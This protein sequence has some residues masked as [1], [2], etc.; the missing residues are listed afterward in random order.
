MYRFTSLFSLAA[1]FA[2]C[3]IEDISDDVDCADGKCDGGKDLCYAEHRYSNGTCDAECPQT[4]VDCLML[5]DDQAQA[6]AW[7]GELEKTIAMQ[8]VRQPRSFVATNDPRFVRMRELLDRGWQSYKKTMPVKM[9]PKTPELV[10]IDDDTA[11]AFVALDRASNKAAW[12]VM[13]QTGAIKDQSDDALLGVVM[14]ELTHATKLHVLPT[15]PDR[16]R[17]H[18]QVTP[19]K[20]EPFGFQ[21]KDQANARQAITAWRELGDAAGPNAHAELNGMPLGGGVLSTMLNAALGTANPANCQATSAKATAVNQFVAAHT[22]P[23]TSL[24]VVSTAADRTQLDQLTRALLSDL[25]DI[26]LKDSTLDIFQLMAQTFGVSAEEVAAEFPVEEQTRLKGKHIIDQITLMAGERHQLMRE[27]AS[28]V[29][30]N[31]GRDI[32]TLRYFSFEE[33]ADDATVPVLRDMGLAVDGVGQFFMNLMDDSLRAQC[34]AA[35]SGGMT[36]PYGDLV[37]E[38]HASCWRVAHVKQL[39]AAGSKTA[40][41]VTAPEPVVVHDYSRFLGHE[42]PRWRRASDDTSSALHSR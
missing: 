30:Q 19:G 40:Y 42:L 37:D 3:A 2:G 35:M 21:Q 23:L 12:V 13:V 11:N 5:F 1:L 9:I 28:E 34:T 22:D 39:G 18:Y 7:F 27:L 24:L 20:A 15:G 33:Q 10:V 41:E 8:E 26:C 4:D 17:V 14:H 31:T 38:H 25:R 32:T 29:Q 36:P 6:S 16:V